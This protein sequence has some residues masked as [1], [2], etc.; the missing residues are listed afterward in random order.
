[1]QNPYSSVKGKRG[2]AAISCSSAAL[3]RWNEKPGFWV[4]RDLTCL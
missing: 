2:Y 1:L 4:V 3:Q